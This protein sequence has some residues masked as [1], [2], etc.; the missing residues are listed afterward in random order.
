M[1]KE[2]DIEKKGIEIVNINGVA[3]EHFAKLYNSD[4]EDKR[5]ASRCAIIT[6]DDF[7]MKCIQKLNLTKILKKDEPSF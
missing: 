3:F 6:D 4:D 7:I 1:G 2:Y 5:L